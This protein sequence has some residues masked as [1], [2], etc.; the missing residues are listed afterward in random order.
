MNADALPEPRVKHF[1]QLL[2]FMRAEYPQERMLV[3]S[4]YL[5]FL[6]LCDEA[7]RKVK[8]LQALRYDGTTPM[9]ERT[10]VFEVAKMF[11]RY[12]PLLL[13]VGAGDLGL[14][15]QWASVLV[16]LD[17]LWNANTE[18]QVYCRVQQYRQKNKIKL[19]RLFAFNSIVD[20]RIKG[21]QE[22]N[23]GAVNHIFRPL[24]LA[25][26]EQPNLE[27]LKVFEGVMRLRALER[28]LDRHKPGPATV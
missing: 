27:K 25:P 2:H 6:D 23:K 3:F 16:Q 9:K 14:N 17:I 15:L 1:L 26:G 13:T 19:F 4:Q 28:C 5:S 20:H 10:L 24:I 12:E 8:D 22:A 7:L 11:S 18:A 21:W